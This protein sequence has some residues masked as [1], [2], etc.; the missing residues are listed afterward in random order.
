MIPNYDPPTRPLW[1]YT[2]VIYLSATIV[3]YLLAV[4]LVKPGA[5]L[6]VCAARFGRGFVEHCTNY[7]RA[8]RNVW[9]KL[10][11]KSVARAVT[12]TI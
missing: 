4:Q 5:A 11:C 9:H 7:R 1:H 10:G 3:L 6:A 8:N 12:Q 2:V